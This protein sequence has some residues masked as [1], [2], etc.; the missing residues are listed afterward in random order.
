MSKIEELQNLIGEVGREH[1]YRSIY[2]HQTNLLVE[3]TDPARDE[4]VGDFSKINFRGKSVLDL[5]CN[6]G[7]F[8]FLARRLGAIR[9]LGIDNMPKIIEGCRLLT[10]IYGLGNIEF[11]VADFERLQPVDEQFDIVMLFEYIGK[12]SLRKNKIRKLLSTLES[13]SKK[14][15]LLIVSPAYIIQ[16]EL[17]IDPARLAQYYSDK[18]M[19][20]EY[21]ELIS[22][23]EECLAKN[24]IMQ[25]VSAIPQFYQKG[26]KLIRFVRR[27][28]HPG[29]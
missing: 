7:F 9:V 10:S 18:Y 21:F 12:A 2:D 11:R 16:E 6:F 15:L 14:E 5:G 22:C 3:G 13:F 29:A 4:L 1:V 17:E 26:K 27:N 28:S 8:S 19:N 20:K 25:P 23:I 24:W